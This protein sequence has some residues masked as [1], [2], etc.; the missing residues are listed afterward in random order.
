MDHSV[1]HC[2]YSTFVLQFFEYR[3]LGG[4]QL[5]TV[6]FS[7]S[8]DRC[9]RCPW[10]APIK[11]SCRC[12]IDVMLL[13]CVCCTRLI[14]TRIT[15]C[16]LSFHLFLSECNILELRLQLILWSLKYQGVERPNFQVFLA[17]PGWFPYT[18]LGFRV[19]STIAAGAS[20]VAKEI[21]KLFNFYCLGLCCW[22]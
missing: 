16:S 18:M 1:W 14:L 10:F 19:Q 5:L 11:V 8:S 9:I 2:W 6:T 17:V 4:G 13:F 12:V 3:S 20:G 22:F 15:V 21:N 7:F